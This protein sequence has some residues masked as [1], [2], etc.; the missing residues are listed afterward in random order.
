MNSSEIINLDSIIKLHAKENPSKTALI[1][2]DID[3][4]IEVYTYNLDDLLN[5][6]D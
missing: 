6:E 4:N 5:K 2:V 3:K 1:F